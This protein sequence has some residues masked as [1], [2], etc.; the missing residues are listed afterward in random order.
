MTGWALKEKQKYEKKGTRKRI[1]K[2][3]RR[4]LEGYFLAGNANKSDCY[5]VQDMYKSLQ[6]RVLEG[7]IEAEAVPKVSTIQN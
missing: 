4:I 3:V 1:S 6:Q 5:T 2:Q 7:D